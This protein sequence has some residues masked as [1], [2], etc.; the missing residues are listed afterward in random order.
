VSGGLHGDWH[1]TLGPKQ[2]EDPLISGLRPRAAAPAKAV[3][4]RGTCDVAAAGDGDGS[5]VRTTTRDRRGRDTGG[6]SVAR[7]GRNTSCLAPG[8]VAR[9]IRMPWCYP[10][11]VLSVVDRLMS[12]R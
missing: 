8:A 10:S 4:I 2:G 11:L 12:S 7:A 5:V 6:V 1:F 3:F 9:R